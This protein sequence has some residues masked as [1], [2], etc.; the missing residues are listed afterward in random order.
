VDD[1]GRIMGG[2]HCLRGYGHSQNLPQET[3]LISS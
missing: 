3:S 1:P 2:P